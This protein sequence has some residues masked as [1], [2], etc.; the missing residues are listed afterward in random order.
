MFEH[1]ILLCR[2]FSGNRFFQDKR[3]IIS[4]TTKDISMKF[5]LNVNEL[6][7]DTL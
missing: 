5:L 4:E 6:Y 1:K 2:Q 3:P 7:I